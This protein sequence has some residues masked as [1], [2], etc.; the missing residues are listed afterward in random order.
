VPDIRHRMT[1]TVKADVAPGAGRRRFRKMDGLLCTMQ[2]LAERMRFEGPVGQVVALASPP[3]RSPKTVNPRLSHRYQWK[4]HTEVNYKSSGS[5]CASR[6][7][8]SKSLYRR[9][10][11]SMADVSQAGID[12]RDF[13][14]KQFVRVIVDS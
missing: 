10:T 8:R 13:V 6:A 1:V 7:R 5:H 11:A 2:N 9:K 3:P 4:Y 14:H 12:P